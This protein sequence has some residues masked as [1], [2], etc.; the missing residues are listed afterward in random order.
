MN[1][2]SIYFDTWNTNTFNTVPWIDPI[3]GAKKNTPSYLVLE[4]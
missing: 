2:K 4:F 3:T 1:K